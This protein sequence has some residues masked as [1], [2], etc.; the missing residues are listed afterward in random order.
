MAGARRFAPADQAGL[1]FHVH[2][3]F[4][5]A[6]GSLAEKEADSGGVSDIAGPSWQR[7]DDEG[8]EEDEGDA[9]QGE[10]ADQGQ[11]P[12]D[13]GDG[14]GQ[15]QQPA[16]PG[17]PADVWGHGFG[18]AGGPATIGEVPLPQV[19]PLR[20][21]VRA[22]AVSQHSCKGAT[23]R[24]SCI[25]GFGFGSGGGRRRRADHLGGGTSQVSSMAWGGRS[26]RCSR[27]HIGAQT[28]CLLCPALNIEPHDLVQA[29]PTRTSLLD[30]QWGGA[31]GWQAGGWP[32][33]GSSGFG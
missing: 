9:D 3:C 33:A 14:G 21:C 17:L 11:E 18:G 5:A 24:A 2:R 19:C 10:E 8:E 25:P 12:D 29:T 6:A 23:P 30:L 15:A 20:E 27:Q 4:V 26:C 7:E 16:L 28:A 31:A 22:S 1:S 13:G 32:P